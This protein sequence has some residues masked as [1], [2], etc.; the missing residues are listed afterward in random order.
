MRRPTSTVRSR[1]I[2]KG[3]CTGLF[4]TLAGRRLGTRGRLCVQAGR[5]RTAGA[6]ARRP[7]AGGVSALGTHN[8]AFRFISP[9]VMPLTAPL[10]PRRRAEP[11][12]QRGGFAACSGVAAADQ[13]I[14]GLL[15]TR[16]QA[17]GSFQAA[18]SAGAWFLLLFWA[19]RRSPVVG[20]RALL[21][22]ATLMAFAM[23]A[24]GYP[25][26]VSYAAMAVLLACFSAGDHMLRGL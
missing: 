8:G 15:G 18:L 5:S 23:L 1:I 14:T 17:V 22:A 24:T 3:G 6:Q 21:N 9:L 10:L 16:W 20:L 11:D 12:C 26:A 25:L 4:A 19:A 2:R 13:V 7:K